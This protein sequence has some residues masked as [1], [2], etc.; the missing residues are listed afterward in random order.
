MFNRRTFFRRTV[1]AALAGFVSP[2]VVKTKPRWV[3]P[4]LYRRAVVAKYYDGAPPYDKVELER[5]GLVWRCN[6][7]FTRL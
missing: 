3:I 7:T 2:L 6:R 4:I 5:T 1:G